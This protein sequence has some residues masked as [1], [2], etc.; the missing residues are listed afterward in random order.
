MVH[1]AFILLVFSFIDRATACTN[2]MLNWTWPGEYID[3]RS[4]IWQTVDEKVCV[5]TS[6]DENGFG[7]TTHMKIKCDN[8]TFCSF[9][10]NDSSFGVSCA[11]HCSGLSYIYK[12]VSKSLVL[13]IILIM[14]TNFTRKQ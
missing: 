12:C 9:S 13:R 1:F 14:L 8:K 3:I 4:A 6:A 11:G 2:T 7:V 5:K 10:V